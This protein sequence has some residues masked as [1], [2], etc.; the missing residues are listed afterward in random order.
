[1]SRSID[2][3]R[4]WFQPKVRFFLAE[5]E[6]DGLPLRVTRTLTTE[7]VQHAIWKVGRELLTEDEKIAMLAEGLY[8][9]DFT[10]TRT[11]AAHANLTP[12]GSR[13]AFDCLPL[14]DG[15]VWLN[16]P[17]E[18]WKR[19]YTIAERCGLD[20]LGDPWGEFVSWD[21]GHFQEGGWRI[22]RG[23]GWSK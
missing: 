16:P 15:K 19:L 7:L 18:V 10:R 5:A 8:P 21:K 9:D 22:Y 11:N 13:L 4:P 1:M 17:D 23:D 20:A 2:D 6:R 3:L 14:K 12:H